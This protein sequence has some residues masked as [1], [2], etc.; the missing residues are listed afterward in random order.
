MCQR[1]HN[2]YPTVIVDRIFDLLVDDCFE[3][4]GR[5]S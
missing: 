4:N 1:S 3:Q 5:Q 2:I